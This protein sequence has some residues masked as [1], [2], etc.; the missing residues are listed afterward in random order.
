[1]KVKRSGFVYS[2]YKKNILHLWAVA[3]VLLAGLVWMLCGSM[4]YLMNYLFYGNA[5]DE[6][7]ISA[8]LS[9]HTFDVD[10]ANEAI[11]AAVADIQAEGGEA[12]LNRGRASMF[13]KT[14][15]YQE[16][17]HYRFGLDLEGLEDTGIYYDDTY[18]AYTGI[19]DRAQLGNVIPK[20]NYPTEHLLIM[21]YGGQRVLAAVNYDT[22]L[23]Q[24]MRVT[25][26]PVSVYEGFWVEDLK[27]AGYEGVFSDYF[28]DL[29][30]T[31]VDFEDEDLKDFAMVCPIVLLFLIPAILFTI[32]PVWHPTYHQLN[33]YGRTT[34]KAVEKVD[35][36]FEEFGILSEEKKTLY[37]DDWLVKKS[38]F[39]NGIE[40]NYKNQKN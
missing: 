35:A 30:Q 14:F 37:L 15:V 2:L 6:A 23:T 25:F 20:E 13:D 24:H 39:K 4:N 9:E 1:M 28:I 34:Q 10:E 16:G 12:T 17:S 8:F 18:R 36:N 29:R 11:A 3:L 27:A 21:N 19:S 22:E 26:A 31:P 5:P 40:K 7:G 33:K 38:F 32:V